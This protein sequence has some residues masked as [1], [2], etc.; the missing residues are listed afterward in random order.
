[1]TPIF[2]ESCGNAILSAEDPCPHCGFLPLPPLGPPALDPFFPL[3]PVST[4]KFVVMSLFTFSFYYLY[5]IY[6]NWCRIA[7]SQGI[8]II[9]FWRMMFS[10]IWN[11]SLFSKIRDLARDRQIAVGWNPILF[12]ALT[13]IAS[14]FSRAGSGFAIIAMLSFLLVVPINQ[15]VQKI[16]AH[17]AQ[18]VSEPYN[19]KFSGGNI[20]VV[21]FGA[22]VWAF[23]LLGIM[24][25]LVDSTSPK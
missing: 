19:D 25:L 12:G 22:I 14:L 20:A 10:G 23:V 24:V 13:L 2:C 6:A 5:W 9:P 18:T 3:F 4:T 15:T 17:H 11:F 16:N 7:Y 21:I 1:M 8:S